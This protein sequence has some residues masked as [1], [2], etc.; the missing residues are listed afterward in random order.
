MNGIFDIKNIKWI[1]YV[2]IDI[3]KLLIHKN[4]Q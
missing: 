2:S 1:I 4:I 3:K